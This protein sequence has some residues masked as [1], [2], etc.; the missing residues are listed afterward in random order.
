MN[1]PRIFRRLYFRLFKR[2]R[3]LEHRFVSYKEA[4]RLI[5]ATHH[6][7]DEGDRWELA[8]PEEDHNR[9]PFMVHLCRQVR[10]VE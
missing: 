1:P 2:Y 7:P 6:L 8:L 10:I 3:R 9:V 4:D 5:R